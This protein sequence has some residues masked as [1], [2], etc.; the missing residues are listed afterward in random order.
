MNFSLNQTTALNSLKERK[1]EE[2]LNHLCDIMEEPDHE[3]AATA[4]QRHFENVI[5]KNKS[6]YKSACF[7]NYTF[8][9]YLYLLCEK[10][11][12]N[13]CFME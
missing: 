12:N 4:L 3:R 1:A 7:G 11:R 13:K 2:F 9:S 10:V 6:L 5:S 8:I